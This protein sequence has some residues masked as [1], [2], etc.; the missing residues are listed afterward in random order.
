MHRDGFSHGNQETASERQAREQ[1]ES[2][3]LQEECRRKMNE[4]NCMKEK[5]SMAKDRVNKLVD[6]TNTLMNSQDNTEKMIHQLG[7]G[8]TQLQS[9]MDKLSCK[10]TNSR[11][12]LN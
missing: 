7:A 11:A 6:G 1:E 4:L 3:Q 8:R 2:R 12:E 5:V 9:D 10:G